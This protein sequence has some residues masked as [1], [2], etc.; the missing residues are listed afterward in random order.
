MEFI[1]YFFVFFIGAMF[2]SFFHVVGYRFLKGMNFVTGRS[3][4]PVCETQLGALDLV[5]FFSY[6][7]LRGKCRHCGAKIPMIYWLAEVIMGLLFLVPVF[8]YGFEGFLTG[9]I[10]FAWIFSSMLFTI[11]VTDIYEQLIP[12]KILL[13]FGILL[14]VASYFVEGF[15]LR[16]GFIGALVGFGLLYAIGTLGRLYYKQDALGGGDVK[17]Y[18][19]IGYMLGWPATL[20]SLFV[21]SIL[22]LIGATST[23][24]KQGAIIPFGPFIAVAALMCFYFGEFVLSWYWG[25]F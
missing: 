15:S 19:I 20:L 16:D 12:D 21:A 10:M 18:A 5:P 8:V 2:G 22:A 23:R 25:L 9:Q 1:I 14:V 17:L 4:C 11:T 7:I 13:F 6:V 3:E 24:Q